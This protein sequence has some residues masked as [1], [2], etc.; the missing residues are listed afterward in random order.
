MKTILIACIAVTAMPFTLSAD[1]N[2]QIITGVTEPKEEIDLAFPE[3]GILSAVAVNE[4]DRV[5]KGQLLMELESSIQVARKKIA[6]IRAG[7]LAGMRSARA[8]M[9]M[10]ERRLEQVRGLGARSSN[11]DELA[12]AEADFE[13]ATAS[14]QTAEEGAATAAIELELVEAEIERRKLRSPINGIVVD[15]LRDVGESL[16]GADAI[17]VKVVDLSALHLVV[18]M[19]SSEAILLHEGS[20]LMVAPFNTSKESPIWTRATLEFVSPVA[21][22]SS[23]TR[24]VRLLL[25]NSANQH[26]SGVKYQIDLGSLSGENSGP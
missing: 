6:E 19:K 3:T 18:H 20:S 10:R 7:S 14:F 4:G 16:V 17:A 13:M 25:E 26:Q 24:K 11:P 2:L 12:R 21:N 8:E 5:E 23:G 9:Q 1:P 15:I 22:V